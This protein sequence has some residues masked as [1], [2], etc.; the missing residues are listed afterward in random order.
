MWKATSETSTH[1]T[2]REHGALSKLSFDVAL[3]FS[4]ISALIDWWEMMATSS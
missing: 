1:I 2:E 4:C 3:T